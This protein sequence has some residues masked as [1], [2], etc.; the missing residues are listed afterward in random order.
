MAVCFLSV[1][2]DAWGEGRRKG[3]H[4]CCFRRLHSTCVMATTS[5]PLLAGLVRAGCRWGGPQLHPT[6][7]PL[8]LWPPA[9]PHGQPMTRISPKVP[10]WQQA[11][12]LP[13]PHNPHY[14]FEVT[15]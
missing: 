3:K 2:P 5:A 15:C 4:T 14:T 7:S 10:H 9:P 1:F 11:F 13:S 6:A 8:A 12:P